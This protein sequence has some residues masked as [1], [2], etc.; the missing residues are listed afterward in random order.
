MAEK[1]ETAEQN[2]IREV[3]EECNLDFVPTSILKT[4][5]WQD[6]AFY[7]FLGNWSGIIKIQ[8]LEVIDYNWFTYNQANKLPLSFDYKEVVELLYKKNLL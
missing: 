7:R 6:R 5:I 8:E 3:K 2:V 4:G 1:D